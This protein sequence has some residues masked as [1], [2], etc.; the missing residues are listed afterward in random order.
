MPLDFLLTQEASLTT[1][2]AQAFIKQFEAPRAWALA[3]EPQYQMTKT[4][5]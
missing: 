5:S 3:N 2:L 1:N 4:R